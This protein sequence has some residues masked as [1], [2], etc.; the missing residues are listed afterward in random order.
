M[1]CH[2]LKRSF[3]YVNRE[4]KLASI[5]RENIMKH[6]EKRHKMSV[7]GIFKKNVK[8]HNSQTMLASWRHLMR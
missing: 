3:L 7:L 8:K 2:Y 5:V 1:H 6:G 4:L